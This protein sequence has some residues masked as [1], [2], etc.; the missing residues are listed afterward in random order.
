MNFLADELAEVTLV[1][2]EVMPP[3][4]DASSSDMA[5]E[6]VQQRI[7]RLPTGRRELL[8]TPRPGRRVAGAADRLSSGAQELTASNGDSLEL[9]KAFH[10]KSPRGAP[11]KMHP[12]D[13]SARAALR[14]PAPRI[15]SL[16]S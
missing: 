16:A 11:D 2:F 14:A 7:C 9:R 3:L 15:P 5:L 13:L 4:P 1:D 8:S 6:V 12:R 10:I